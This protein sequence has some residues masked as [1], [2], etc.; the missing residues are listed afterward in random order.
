[1]VM[2]P[3]RPERGMILA[4]NALCFGLLHA[5][6]LG[7]VLGGRGILYALPACGA[8]ALWAFV[9]FRSRSLWPALVSHWGAD[10]AILAGC[11]FSS[12][13]RPRDPIIALTR[14]GGMMINR[15]AIPAVGA[16]LF[17]GV[18]LFACGVAQEQTLPLPSD[19]AHYAPLEKYEAMKSRRTTP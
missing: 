4:A 8:G 18:L 2:D 3:G 14:R 6:P 13:G 7:L 19:P 12:S 5:V 11:G 1:M 15:F 9:T 17:S 10:A 16:L